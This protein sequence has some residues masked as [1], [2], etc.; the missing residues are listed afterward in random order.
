MQKQKDLKKDLRMRQKPAM[1]AERTPKNK[2]FL[3]KLTAAI[4][5]CEAGKDCHEFEEFLEKKLLLI[6]NKI[7]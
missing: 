7:K 2:G 3:V 1:V 4:L 5:R 6:K